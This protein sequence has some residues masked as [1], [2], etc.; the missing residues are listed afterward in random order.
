[1]QTTSL[2]NMNEAGRQAFWGWTWR[3]ELG[4]GCLLRVTREYEGKVASVADHPLK[5]AATVVTPYATVG[6]GVKS[7]VAKRA[8]ADLFDTDSEAR[9]DQFAAQARSLIEGCS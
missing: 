5:G 4:A 9:A 7:T 2:R 1:V 3:Y 8:S 6:F